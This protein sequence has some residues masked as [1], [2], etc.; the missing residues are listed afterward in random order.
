MLTRNKKGQ[1]AH[2][3]GEAAPETAGQILDDE[4]DLPAK[5]VETE[6]QAWLPDAHGD[7]TGPAGSCAPPV[8]GPEKA[9]RVR[10]TASEGACD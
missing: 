3:L 4:T 6:A 5:R 1:A 7:E 9:D 8:E 10:R 2:L